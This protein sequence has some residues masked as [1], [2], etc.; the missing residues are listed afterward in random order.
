MVR[1]VA[2]KCTCVVSHELKD[3][4]GKAWSDSFELEMMLKDARTE[5]DELKDKIGALIF[6]IVKH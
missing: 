4:V 6:Y 3:A 2:R 1:D 5:R